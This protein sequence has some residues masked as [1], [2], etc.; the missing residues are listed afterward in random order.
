[1]GQDRIAV[2]FSYNPDFAQKVKTVKEHRWHP[3]EKYWSFP[4][5]NDILDRLA[6]LFKGERLKI[7]PSL[8]IEDKKT[9]SQHTC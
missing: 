4:S 6:S 7:N 8:R 2:S 1:L 5:G 9:V 3:V